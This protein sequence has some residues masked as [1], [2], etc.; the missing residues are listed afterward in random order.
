MSSLVVLEYEPSLF[1]A[2]T[3][4]A[5]KIAAA[6]YWLYARTYWS[7]GYSM[8]EIASSGESDCECLMKQPCLRFMDHFDQRDSEEFDT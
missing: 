6:G 3:V 7:A 2:D 8:S 5:Y 1:V 4:P